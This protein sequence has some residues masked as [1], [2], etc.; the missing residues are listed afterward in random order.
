MKIVLTTLNAKFSHTNLA[1]QYI[2]A[3]SSEF[4]IEIYEYNINQEIDEL[5]RE[6]YQTRADVL[7]FSTYIWNYTES[8]EI[9]NKLKKVMPNLIIVFGGAE[10]S[11]TQEEIMSEEKF[12]DYIVE[13][14]GEETCH[15]LFKYLVNGEGELSEILGVSYRDGDEIIINPPRPLIRDLDSIPSPYPNMEFDKNKIVYY[16]TSR[17]CPFNCQF[18]LSSTIKGLRFFSIERVKSDLAI[19]MKSGVRQIKFVDR[20]FNADQEYSM[21]LMTYIMDNAPDGMNF[22]FEVTAHLVSDEFLEFLSHVKVGLF[23]FEIGVQ[24]SN[25]KTLSAS[26]RTT[27]LDKLREVVKRINSFGNIHQHLDLIVGLPFEGYGSFRESFNYVYSLDGEKVQIGFLKLLKGSGLR[28][29]ADVYGFVYA[30]EAP[31]EIMET[32]E[33]NFDEMIALKLIEDVVEKYHNERYFYHA[34]KYLI[35]N[36]YETP[37]DYFEAVSIFWGERGYNKISHSRN[38]LYKTLYEFASTIL[39]EDLELFAEVL[40][41]DFLS[42]NNQLPFDFMN[43]ERVPMA[44]IHEILK[45]EEILPELGEYRELP[46]KKIIQNVKIE[47]FHYD[48]LELIESN[49]VK[50]KRNL[51]L[52]G[53]IY[54]KSGIKQ[55]DINKF[56]KE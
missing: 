3:Y 54:M 26:G 50:I 8:L 7:C 46:T 52:Y 33:L 55:I 48:I 30:D 5:V 47:Q 15:E 43:T 28:A 49:Y 11:F 17:G 13:G 27:D 23:Q 22:H 44:E 25:L 9:A 56:I 21:E 10:V 4:D 53:F 36:Y 45:R 14:E 19:L 31:Y 37:F 35:A 6:L 51:T 1:I 41:F 34:N 24:S 12:I 32:N 40:A 42:S 16:E 39:D 18:C 20:T 29:M 2:K 38:S